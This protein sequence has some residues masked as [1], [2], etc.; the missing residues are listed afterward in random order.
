MKKWIIRIFGGL[1]TLVLLLFL[2][3]LY[4]LGTESGTT[5]LISQAEKQLDGRLHIDTTKGKVLDRLELTNIVFD[6]PAGKAELGHLVLDWKSTDLLHLH[7]HIL[8]LTAANISYSSVSQSPEP[9]PEDNGPLS[10]PD[11]TL[12]I[13]ITIEK[14]E[15]NDFV[16]HSSPD[17]APL[18][19]QNADLT[20][21]WTKN[22][23]TIQKLKL[24]MPEA[25][26]L[27]QGKVNPVEHYPLQLTTELKTLDSALPS[28]QMSGKIEG[29]LQK[30]VVKESL[31]GDISAELNITIQ[32]VIDALTWQGDLII[33]E[34]RPATFSPK[35]PGSL[36]GI[37]QTSG[38]LQHAAVTAALSIR[39][40]NA[41]EINWDANLDLQANLETLLLTIN[42]LTL[43]HMDSAAQIALSGTADGDQHQDIRLN[44]QELQWPVTGDAEYS[45]TKGE[46]IL[47]G[48]MDAYHL[49][50]N[51]E[52]AGTQIPETSLEIITDGSTESAENLQLTA[53]LL[54]GVI[55]VQGKVQW[56]PAVE[57]HLNID[58][59]DLNPGV[60]Y[61]EWP[62]K[63]NWLI[64]TDG[65]I[66]DAGLVAN[67]T[68]D[69]MQGNLRDLPIAGN[70][71]IQIKP[72]DIHI[73]DFRL[74]SGTAVVTAQGNLG[75]NS[76]L[77]WQVDVTDLS[78]LLP[79]GGGT[80]NGQG[81]VQGE[82]SE[83]QLALQLSG[84][85]LIFP[86]LHMENITADADLDL[87][88]K[89]PFN[90]NVS[91]TN[92]KSGNNLIQDFEIQGEGSREQHTVHLTANHDLANISLGL[93][94]GYLQ[95]Q[96]KGMLNGFNIESTDLGAWKLTEPAEINGG[97]TEAGIDIFCLNREHADLCLKASWNKE[98]TNTKGDIALSGF[99]LA[100]LSPW[101]PDTVQD[102]TGIFSLTAAANMQGKLQADLLA[103]ITPGS[104]AYQ[105]EKKEGSLPHE[106][107]KIDIHIAEDALDAD[108]FLSL[109]SNIIRGNLKSPD[110]LQ[111]DIGS[112][113]R[114]AG[115]MFIDADK[116]DLIETLVADVQD[117][118]AAVNAN[119]KILG[120]LEQPDINGSGK[121]N[122]SNIL[123]PVAGL[124]LKNTT[125]DI[126]ANNKDLKINGL[127]NSPKGSLA[128]DGT[129]V[130]D[131]SQ[132][133][134]ARFTLKGKNFRLINLPEIEVFLTSDLL[135]EKTNN[136][137]S[138]TGDVT[139]PRADILLRDLPQGTKTASPDVKIIQD[140][141]PEETKS[142]V[143]MK[144]KL[145]LGNKV[146]FA[147]L[148]LNAFIDGQLS[149]TAEPDKQMLGSG[150]FHIK[151]GSFR[152][153]GQNLDIE[154]GVISF[155]G[156]PLSQPGINLRATRTVGGI[157]AGIYAIGPASKPRL[158]TFSNPP[159]S[160]SQVISYLLTGSAPNDTG[161]GVSL[162]VG[163]QI[164][165]KLSVSV[166]TNI[167]T[168]D[169][170]FVTRYRLS[171]K[172]HVETTTAG[173]GNAV[174]IFYTI[175]RGGKKKK[176]EQEK[177]E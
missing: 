158:T 126:L 109:N 157:V 153:Y 120:T 69:R 28:L 97:K 11:L 22:G 173:N 162:S 177:K 79:D 8:E 39:D 9:E 90:L 17:A 88:W 75:K 24:L 156:G 13:T 53:N 51:A 62:G 105:T 146:H 92:L 175:E 31:N 37:I 155:P 49:T 71:T 137:L 30:L 165:N 108:L 20:L 124:E 76:T 89:A 99:P 149:I 144:L 18:T 5:F 148:G 141:E 1:L 86:G 14:L 130:L 136:L 104:I 168:G 118:N 154:T 152:A 95:E 164:N 169:S 40:A 42:Q 135:L 81:T 48:S 87:S 21:T 112:K 61:A 102:L 72:D 3:G 66:D 176:K 33:E 111:T 26:L 54:E 167:K 117:L 121:I 63:L 41:A 47:K 100:W 85:N 67:V 78:N 127:F 82:M 27:V 170:E 44:W 50:L 34:L 29:D 38:N 119:F 103:E 7:L 52:I 6:S 125:L 80:L 142:P 56:T 139:I 73:N 107:M 83:P 65:N 96:W 163:R 128:L 110:L 60:Q 12:P 45:S 32:Q 94:G 106:G 19:V 132:N 114:L 171:R 166:G 133:W 174:D 116:L 57:W 134:P 143:D 36:Q 43:K 64:K 131:S 93:K 70:G 74:S 115:E 77:N 16:F 15:I 147:G 122:I 55:G 138:L 140:A 25:S 91:G 23:I 161:K 84:S 151:Q 113:A 145:T 58:G 123:I 2:G 101:F 160:E 159:M 10:L 59:K 35:I 98:N 150:A 4:L 46:V 129:A 172:I 68:I